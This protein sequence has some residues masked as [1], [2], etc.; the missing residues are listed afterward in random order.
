MITGAVQKNQEERMD[1]EAN[2]SQ[3]R[4]SAEAHRI[5]AAANHARRRNP[6]A[7]TRTALLDAPP[8]DR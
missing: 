2:A 4:P 1:T 5:K 3:S 7:P 6:P 8:L